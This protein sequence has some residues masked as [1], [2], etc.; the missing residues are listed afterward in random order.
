MAYSILTQVNSTLATFAP[1]STLS[2]FTKLPV[3]L[4]RAASLSSKFA[5][6]GIDRML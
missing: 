5:P 4:I 2:I 3:L 6:A 1:S